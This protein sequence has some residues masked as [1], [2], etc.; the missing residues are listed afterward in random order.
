MLLESQQA[1]AQIYF[2]LACQCHLG[3][4]VMARRMAVALVVLLLVRKQCAGGR[5]C[6]DASTETSAA[7]CCRGKGGSEQQ[8]DDEDYEEREHNREAAGV[9]LEEKARQQRLIM[10]KVSWQGFCVFG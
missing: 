6:I 7:N 1:L 3:H 10:E 4:L 2:W 5:D 9:G 8:A